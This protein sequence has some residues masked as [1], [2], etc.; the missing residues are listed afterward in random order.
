MTMATCYRSPFCCVLLSPFTE[1][2]S[3]ELGCMPHRGTGEGCESKGFR[4]YL[5]P[6]GNQP[7]VEDPSPQ[8]VQHQEPEPRGRSCRL[9]AGDG[10]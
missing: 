3:A 2:K 7:V 1:S 10:G 4:E 6:S 8:A 5:T 9:H